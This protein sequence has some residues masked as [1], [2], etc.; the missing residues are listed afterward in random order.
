MAASLPQTM[1]VRIQTPDK[2][3]CDVQATFV[4]LS[5]TEGET[6]ILPGHVALVGTI[7]S[8]K[9]VLGTNEH[10]EKY[11]VR[12]G[13]VTIAPG[14]ESVLV[15]VFSCTKEDEVNYVTLQQ[16]RDKI[17]GLLA[18]GESLSALQVKFLEDERIALEGELA[19]GKNT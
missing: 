11:R 18:K 7:A 4:T 10:E 13:F 6:Q 9:V 14:G 8:S 15:S 3:H 17:L 5:T 16:Y 2:E 1:R 12:N 19:E